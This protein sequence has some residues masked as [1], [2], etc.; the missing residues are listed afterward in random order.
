[1]K[2]HVSMF[3]VLS[4]IATLFISTVEAKGS[5]GGRGGGSRGGSVSRPSTPKVSTPKTTT[6]KSAPAPAPKQSTPKVSSKPSST[7]KTTTA[8]TNK[9]VGN[10]TFSKKGSVVDENY[11][12]KFRGGVTPPAGSTVYYRQNSFMDYLP[13]I[14]IFTH[15]SHRDAIVTQTNEKGEVVKEEVVEE[16]GTDGMYI[17]NWIMVILLTGGIIGGIIWFINKKT[18]KENYV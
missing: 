14:Y 16:E 3:V 18:R 2:K 12:P 17:F 1:M 13:W 6:P 11:Q 15:D 7:T 5:S 10:K 9:T 4:L 8:Q